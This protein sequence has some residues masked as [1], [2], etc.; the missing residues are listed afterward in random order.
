MA[1]K[2]LVEGMSCEHCVKHVKEALAELNGVTKVDVNL[3]AKFATVEAS[4]EISDED[5][6]AAIDD[7]GYEVVKIETL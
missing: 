7:A 4:V 3:S 2:I 6:K 1:K 5:I